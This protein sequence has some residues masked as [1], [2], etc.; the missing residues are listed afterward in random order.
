ML[1]GDLGVLLG[2]QD[3]HHS[4]D[5]AGDGASGRR[6]VTACGNGLRQRLVLQRIHG[7]ARRG[8]VSREHNESL[9]PAGRTPTADGVVS[10]EEACPNPAK[11]F[12]KLEILHF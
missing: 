4:F 3:N 8:V 10:Q 1:R 2:Q 6:V 7:S 11:A 5:A 9:A 12:R